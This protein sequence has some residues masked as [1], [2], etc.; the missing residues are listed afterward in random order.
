M[1]KFY[2]KQRAFSAFSHR[3][4]IK[5]TSYISYLLLRNIFGAIG[6]RKDKVGRNNKLWNLISG[7]YSS[8]KTKTRLLWMFY[9]SSGEI[10]MYHLYHERCSSLIYGHNPLHDICDLTPQLHRRHHGT[11]QVKIFSQ[12]TSTIA[13]NFK[14]SFLCDEFI[15]SFNLHLH[16]VKR[17]SNWQSIF[18]TLIL[19]NSRLTRC[20]KKYQ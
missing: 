1:S 7:M 5:R 18:N 17:T 15:H 13:P 8:C 4:F 10:Y 11:A 12:I 6:N 3:Y 9:G 20:Y 2:I 19:F 14:K 16:D